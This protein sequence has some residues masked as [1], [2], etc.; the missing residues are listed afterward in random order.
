VCVRVFVSVCVCVCVWARALPAR[1][2]IP[3]VHFVGLTCGLLS[4]H[5]LINPE[6]GGTNYFETS[7]AVYQSTRRNI[8]GGVSLH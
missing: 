3:L 2:F 5:G 8:P 7:V 6:D 4:L 1:V